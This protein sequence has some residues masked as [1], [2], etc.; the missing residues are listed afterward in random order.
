M[1]SVEQSVR[2]WVLEV[3]FEGRTHK[4]YYSSQNNAEQASRAFCAHPGYYKVHV[5]QQGTV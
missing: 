5:Y 3:N 2:D 1:K 4:Y